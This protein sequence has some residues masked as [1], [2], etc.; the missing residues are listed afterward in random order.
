MTRCL[1]NDINSIGTMTPPMIDSID[2]I[3]NM[4]QRNLSEKVSLEMQ[5]AAQRIL[6]DE[7]RIISRNSF[8]E[9]YESMSEIVEKLSKSGSPMLVISGLQNSLVAY[10]LGITKIN[11]IKFNLNPFI[12]YGAKCDRE[13]YLAFYTSSGARE[14]MK[15]DL[16]D[17]YAKVDG[18]AD[19]WIDLSAF[20][21]TSKL[22]D[23]AGKFILPEIHS[24]SDNDIDE[25]SI[26]SDENF[27]E[28]AIPYIAEFSSERLSKKD[29]RDIFE[30]IKPS[31]FEHF[32]EAVGLTYNT[33]DPSVYYKIMAG[34]MYGSQIPYCRD[35]IYDYLVQSGINNNVAYDVMVKVRKGVFKK[36]SQTADSRF[37]SWVSCT[38][39]L[40]FERGIPQWYMEALEVIS[41]LPCKGT[42]IN[43]SLYL[44]ALYKHMHRIA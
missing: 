10:L 4:C 33:F 36:V 31:C 11:P 29:I 18:E 9:D 2:R 32:I 38:K 34:E 43:I 35:N 30:L 14:S 22:A 42:L 26:V 16:Y 19:A 8:A 3:T 15:K 25:N 21:L 23:D 39:T 28:F 40:M 24:F 7:L 37:A 27:W 20:V 17:Y 41:Y 13:P 5:Y 6:E 1:T 44:I 12:L